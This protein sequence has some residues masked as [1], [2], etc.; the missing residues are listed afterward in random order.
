[1]ILEN[2]S[3]T[4]FGPPQSPPSTR[5]RRLLRPRGRP[6]RLDRLLILLFLLILELDICFSCVPEARYRQQIAKAGAGPDYFTVDP[7]VLQSSK[8]VA[9]RAKGDGAGGTS[10][11]EEKEVGGDD[12]SLHLRSYGPLHHRDGR[13][14]PALCEQKF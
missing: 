5:R 12:T 9:D 1:M 13:C 14:H 3:N 6:Q 10:E 4:S 7:G 2:Y 11:G 8:I